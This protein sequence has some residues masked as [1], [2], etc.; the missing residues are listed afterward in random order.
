MAPWVQVFVHDSGT[1]VP[2]SYLCKC[3]SCHEVL[4]VEGSDAP[5]SVQLLVRTR[6]NVIVITARLGSEL[7]RLAGSMGDLACRGDTIRYVTV[8]HGPVLVPD[9]EWLAVAAHDPSGEVPPAATL[10]G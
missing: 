5:H 3:R 1:L 8:M 4:V 2:G 7:A 9:K 6:R 10:R